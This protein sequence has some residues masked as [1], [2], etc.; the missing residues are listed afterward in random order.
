MVEQIVGLFLTNTPKRLGAIR[1]GIEKEEWYGAER[2][3]HSMKS[4]SGSL[5]LGGIMDI[6][7]RLELACEGHR[8]EDAPGLLEELET[9]WKLMKPK[10]EQ[11]LLPPA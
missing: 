9:A 3:A 7:S 2:G 11:L 4:A 5:G 1:E 6:A 10:V 8:A